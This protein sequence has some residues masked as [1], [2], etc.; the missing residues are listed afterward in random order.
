MFFFGKSDNTGEN[1][2]VEGSMHSFTKVPEPSLSN[3]REQRVGTTSYGS[4]SYRGVSVYSEDRSSENYLAMESFLKDK[5]PDSRIEWFF[6]EAYLQFFL[7]VVLQTDTLTFY[8]GLPIDLL[9]EDP[10]KAVVVGLMG[11]PQ[12]VAHSE[13]EPYLV[14]HIELGEG[15]DKL[16]EEIMSAFPKSQAISSGFKASRVEE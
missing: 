12:V 16:C 8:E 10:D 15:T 4:S 1:S 2:P 11:N 6:P 5:F 13:F 7:D 3:L 9:S 14:V